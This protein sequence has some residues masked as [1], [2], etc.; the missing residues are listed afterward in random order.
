[1]QLVTKSIFYLCILLILSLITTDIA[2]AQTNPSDNRR[3]IKSGTQYYDPND[4]LIAC[5]ASNI[6]LDGADNI[7]KIWNFF[8]DPAKNLKDYQIAGIMGNIEHES[9]FNPNAAQPS[10]TKTAEEYVDLGWHI[11]SRGHAYGIVQWDPGSKLVDNA[12]P[13][14]EANKL[15]FQLN[16]LWDQLNGNGPVP[17]NP[18]I[19]EQIRST[20]TTLEAVL[21]FQGNKSVGGDYIGFERPADQRGTVPDRL[22]AAELI[23]S[24]YQGV[25]SGGISA[26]EDCSLDPV[27]GNLSELTLSYAWPTYSRGPFLERKPAYSQAVEEAKKRGEYVGGT[28]DGVEGIDCGGFVTRLVINSNFDSGYNYN[29]KGGNTT[30]QEQWLKENWT[31]IY[32]KTTAD[33]QPGDVAIN[34]DHT[35][36]YVGQINGFE[37]LTA[38]ASYS[39]RGKGR[40]PMA[41]SEQPAS[42][43]FNWY[44]KAN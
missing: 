22:A 31:Q 15:E 29:G 14:S 1:V 40:A 20:A 23:L 32:P 26:G 42:S 9:G 38:S 27:S 28:V 7:E 35:Y 24:K 12:K 17:E 33:H 5:N 39:T 4:K 30:T 8:S 34:S 3:S 18:K 36:I 11:G 25:S 10:T 37:S 44:R 16:F 13:L 41:G 21:A 2:I 19:L 43:E 6:T